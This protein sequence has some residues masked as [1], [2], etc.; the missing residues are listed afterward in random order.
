MIYRLVEYKLIM[1]QMFSSLNN[2]SYFPSHLVWL[3]ALIDF[4]SAWSL[5]LNKSIF[6]C[7]SDYISLFAYMIRIV[8]I[9][10]YTHNFW[11]RFQN[12]ENMNFPHFSNHFFKVT[13]EHKI[14]WSVVWILAFGRW[15]ICSLTHVSRSLSKRL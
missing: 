3:Y 13:N 8:M 7:W 5:R 2:C 12:K 1:G 4:L 15:L 6:C 14:T 10:S 9:Y 11:F